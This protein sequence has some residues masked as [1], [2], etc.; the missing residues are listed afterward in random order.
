MRIGR[1]RL[2]VHEWFFEL[3]RGFEAQTATLLRC[4][5]STLT[6]ELLPQVLRPLLEIVQS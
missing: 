1:S 3:F 4:N 6:T 2:E 5:P